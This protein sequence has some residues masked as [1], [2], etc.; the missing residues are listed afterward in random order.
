MSLPPGTP[1][2]KYWVRKKLAEGGMAEIYLCAARGPE[3][4]EKDVVIKRIRPFLANDPEFVRIFVAEARLASRLNHANVVQIFDFDKHDDTYYLAMEYVRGRSL[5]E[6]RKRSKELM[7][8]MSTTLVAHLG[9]EVAR[10]LHYAHR[11]QEHGKPLGLVHRDVTPQNVLVSFDGAIK[12]TD[13]GIAKASDRFTRPGVLKGKFAYMAPE[14]ARG[15]PLDARADVFALGV[16]LWELLTG[17]R[18]F[19]GDSDLAVLKAVQESRI[20]PP[21]RLNPDVPQPLSDIVLKALER[22][23][24]QRFQSAHEL[25]RALA[26]HVL[27]HAQSI[28]DTDVSAYMRQLFADEP[29][30]IAEPAMPSLTAPPVEPKPPE[31]PPAPA[32]TPISGLSRTVRRDELSGP[33]RSAEAPLRPTVGMRRGLLGAAALTLVLGGA[34]AVVAWQARTSGRGGELGPSVEAAPAGAGS[35]E[36]KAPEGLPELEVALPAP[37]PPLTS[38]AA[39][40][41]SAEVAMGR[42]TV[43]AVPWATLYING[44]RRGEVSPRPRNFELP[45]GRYALVFR[46]TRGRRVRTVELSPDKP[47][48][49]GVE[50]DIPSKPGMPNPAGD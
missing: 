22:D 25:E 2:G 38:Q 32:S 26:G 5:W 17:G 34:A 48:F 20:A 49:V 45:V 33:A 40:D 6:V 41:A 19:D 12:L 29:T 10:G 36:P 35:P 9:A 13:F 24:A 14:Q 31:P 37:S 28:D 44:E 7:L 43:R 4:F 23:P 27:A 46:H 21:S 11:L 50:F 8:P 18:L 3:G 39:P 1:I 16:V 15:G 42:L 47:T 30:A